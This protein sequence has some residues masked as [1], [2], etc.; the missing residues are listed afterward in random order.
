MP[1]HPRIHLRRPGDGPSPE[2]S[3]GLELEPGAFGSGEHDTTASCLELLEGLELAGARVLDLGCGTGVLA[4]AA[5]LLGAREAVGVDPDPGAI[6]CSRSNGERNGVG[7]RLTLVAGELGATTEH[8]FD[9]ICANLYADVLE[10]LAPEL[11]GR[12]KPGGWVLLSGILW[13][14]D[15]DLRRR[16]ERLGCELRAHRFL[17]EHTT[18]LWRR[19]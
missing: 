18:Q 13:E 5:L 16:F 7:A 10:P 6:A 11:V 3:L 4:I 12:C 9:L 19:R 15:F 2:G 8:D 1:S 14:L 17:G